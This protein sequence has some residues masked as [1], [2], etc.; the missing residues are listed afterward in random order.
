MQNNYYYLVSSLFELKIDSGKKNISIKEF[1]E[2]CKEEL[3]EADFLNLK[4]IF[5]FN[6]LK[7]AVFCDKENFVFNTPTYFDE[8]EFNDNLNDTDSFF[9]FISEYF[10]YKNNEAIKQIIKKN[11][12]ALTGYDYSS[13]HK[14][15]IDFK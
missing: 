6:D 1:I 5:L 15:K 9:S 12:S 10:F 14:V 3:K 11:V 2:F 13:V 8:T 7:N 4:K